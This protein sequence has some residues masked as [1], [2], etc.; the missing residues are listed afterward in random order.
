K[1]GDLS[2]NIH[3]G[4]GST[5]A[6]QVVLDTANSNSTYVVFKVTGSHT[7]VNESEYSASVDVTDV[8]GSTLTLSRTIKAGDPPISV[9]SQASTLSGLQGLP[10][11]APTNN[12]LATFFVDG[13]ID[14]PG[15]YQTHV[16]WGD[17]TKEED[18]ALSVS[19]NLNQST[20][21]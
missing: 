18:L 20:I 11:N 5:T 14:G 8:G 17:G 10:M 4:D 21:T 16:D 2:A 1:P 13:P 15:D 9:A 19:Q 3:W 7:L 6:G 12:I